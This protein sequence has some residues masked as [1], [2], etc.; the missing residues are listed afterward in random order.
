MKSAEEWCKYFGWMSSKDD[1][2]RVREIQ[3]DALRH[4]AKHARGINEEDDSCLK[5]LELIALDYE[6]QA[7]QLDG[8]RE[9]LWAKPPE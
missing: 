2:G 5:D 7:D 1:R 8:R 9:Q 3:A 6:A 4:A